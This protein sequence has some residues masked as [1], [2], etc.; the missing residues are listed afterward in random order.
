VFAVFVDIITYPLIFHLLRRTQ[1]VVQD[2]CRKFLTADLFISLD[3]FASGVNEASPP[4]YDSVSIVIRIS[5]QRAFDLAGKEDRLVAR[6]RRVESLG[7]IPGGP[8]QEFRISGIGFLRA[9]E[10]CAH[11]DIDAVVLETPEKA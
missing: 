9:S 6:I 8:V 4:A 10:H 3:G 11:P 5:V 7:G 2:T 1:R